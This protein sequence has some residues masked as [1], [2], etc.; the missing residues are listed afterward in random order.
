MRRSLIAITGLIAAAGLGAL[1]A[2]GIAGGEPGPPP[3]VAIDAD[4]ELGPLAVEPVDRP[5]EGAAAL[6]GR[7][8]NQTSEQLAFFQTTEPLEIAPRT[9]EGATLACPKGYKALGGYYVTGRE[10][11][12]LDLT[13]PEVAVPP[14]AE[15]PPGAKPSKR[16]WVL[17][18]YNSTP[19][20]DQV[21]FGV[22]CL[23]K[24]R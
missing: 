18:V 4:R 14:A 5:G 1:A 17:A 12:F 23:K 16:N 8:D 11:T 10:G 24:R 13:A 6:R 19:E 20:T 7:G 2:S 15:D 21:D 22:G 3:P 9:E